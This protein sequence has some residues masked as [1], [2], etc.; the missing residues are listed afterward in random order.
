MDLNNIL[1]N[2]NQIAEKIYIST[3]EEVYKTL[4]SLV[5]ITTDIL[6][7]EPLK[8]LF[9]DNSINVIMLLGNVLIIFN[10]TYFMLT[11]LISMFN[12]NKAE[13]VYSFIFKII[14]VTLLVNNSYFI[15]ETILNFN[16]YLS[17]I[18]SEYG[19]SITGSEITF[20]NL[21]D[22]IVSIEDFLNTD[23][24]S[25]DGIIKGVVSFGA[26]TI[27]INFSIRY[28]MIVILIFLLPVALS[29][30]ASELTQNLFYTF[31]KSLI[32]TLL[33]GPIVKLIIILPLMYKDTGSIMYKIVLVGS[34]YIIYRINTYLK[35][36]FVRVS[37]E[38]SR[39]NIFND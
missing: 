8:H 29:T 38:S 21:K 39:R 11:L 5:N 13:K 15:A 34:I 30:L 2:L 19:N 6:K 12:G 26:V 9:T 14:I 7:Q 25:L 32:V 18:V 31:I 35:E 4:D 10:V 16:T 28:V 20:N 27:L 17:E 33:T 23:L 36:L 3:E 24:I 22:K 1:T 37:K